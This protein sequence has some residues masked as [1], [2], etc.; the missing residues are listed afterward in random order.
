MSDT[1]I[2]VIRPSS[3][4][5]WLDCSRRWAA[6]TLAEEVGAAG[7]TLNPSRPTHVGAAV[8]Q[9]VHGSAGWTMEQ[10]RVTGDLGNATEADQRGLEALAMAA[11]YGVVWDG[12][13]DTLN[14][15]Q[16]QVLRMTYAYRHDLAPILKPL[17]VE[18]RVDGDL[19]DG[20][21][22][23]GQV[24]LLCGDLTTSVDDLKTGT[25]QRAN[26]V[27]YGSYSLLWEM[28]GYKPTII[29]EHFIKR[30]RMDKP[31]PKP[32]TAEMDMR[33]AQADAL[34]A[35]D[36]IKRSTALFHHRLAHGGRPAQSAFRANPGSSLCGAKWCPAHGTNFCTVHKKD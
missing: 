19:G 1:F 36:D 20:W 7:Y 15:A 35:I 17:A 3:L 14:T 33:T 27:Q 23:S 32:L 2:R 34:E 28:K 10:K 13:T 9:G 4:A 8:G 18:E 25:V 30:V 11:E 5:V 31:Q 6:R 26:G 22:L 24:D 12:T 29:R 21:V 16:K